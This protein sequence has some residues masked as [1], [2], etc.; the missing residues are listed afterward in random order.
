MWFKRANLF[1]FTRFVSLS[2]ATT[3]MV[4]VCGGV[5]LM[6][7]L[8][9]LLSLVLTSRLLLLVKLCLCH[10]ESVRSDEI[11]KI[12]VELTHRTV[13]YVSQ[14]ELQALSDYLLCRQ[15]VLC[16]NAVA[17]SPR[18]SMH[19][20]WLSLDIVLLLSQIKIRSHGIWR[21]EIR[22]PHYHSN[23]IRFARKSKY[24]YQYD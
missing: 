10:D 21:H 12:G 7:M 9:L 23:S 20:F 1:A 11:M 13:E 17:F 18:H 2:S 6:L 5:V 8:T 19:M 24:L 4:T 3:T 22:M 14:I 16:W 15:S